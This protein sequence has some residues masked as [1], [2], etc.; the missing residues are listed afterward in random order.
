[1]SRTH[2]LVSAII[3]CYNDGR[4]IHGA[5]QSV[6]AQ[7]YKNIEIIIVD[8]GSEDKETLTIL[9]N[10]NT[11]NT[12]VFRKNNGGPASARNY[13]IERSAGEYILTLDSD[14]KFTPEFVD[15]SLTILKNQPG[16]GM[17][18]SYV[19][20][21]RGEQTSYTKREGGDL[22]S[23]IIKNEANASLLFRYKCW[24][25]VGGY[26]EKIP[27]YEDWEFFIH[28]TKKGWIVYSIPEFLFVHLERDDSVYGKDLNIRPEIIDYLVN[29]YQL[30]FQKYIIDVIDVREKKISELRHSVNMYKN[31]TAYKVGNFIL[32]PLL[33]LKSLSSR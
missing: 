18:T 13:G 25:D 19:K 16:I 26:D 23:F 17:V 1:M 4:F 2:D 9:A 21:Y 27:G 14:D 3:P 20:R 11:P 7:T 15:K 5:I 12:R 22:R 31:S 24:E 10:L 32:K 8:D 6:L 30:D 33:W 29:K 28:V